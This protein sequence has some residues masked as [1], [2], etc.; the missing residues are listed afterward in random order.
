[1]W[2]WCRH[3]CGPNQTR[4]NSVK[5]LILSTQGVLLEASQGD[6]ADHVTVKVISHC[7]V[8]VQ[9]NI[10]HCMHKPFPPVK[11][12]MIIYASP[13]ISCCYSLA[14][15]L[16][17]CVH[18]HMRQTQITVFSLYDKNTSRSRTSRKL[19][20]AKMLTNKRLK[21]IS[22]HEIEEHLN[23]IWA[24]TA[25]FWWCKT[26]LRHVCERDRIW[27]GVKVRQDLREEQSVYLLRFTHWKMSLFG[28]M[29]KADY[30]AN[31][32]YIV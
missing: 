19:T 5:D 23:I 28:V 10:C 16:H 9:E 25:I 32:N 8:W 17:V 29:K 20:D 27:D 4:R 22:A 15:N 26:G 6:T 13:P 12:Q 24:F 31:H 30:E 2:P 14:L 3:T 1:M 11:F 7:D 18:A 21:V